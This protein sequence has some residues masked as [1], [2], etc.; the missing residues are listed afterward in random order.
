LL[1]PPQ[2]EPLHRLPE[3]LR[4]HR[5]QEVVDGVL[6]ERAD[7]ERVVRRDEHD[8]R[9]VLGIEH[10]EQLEPVHDGHVHVEEQ[11]VRR[12]APDRL[13]S[14][15]RVGRLAH[16]EHVAARL[17]ERAELLP[18]VRLVVDE[19]GAK[20]VHAARSRSGTRSVTRVSS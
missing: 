10:R 18:G 1:P 17:E 13:Q 7:R 3:P 11:H 19:D 8:E 2:P 16:H 20:D 9:E 4:R 5:L 15:E 12:V 6:L 14:L